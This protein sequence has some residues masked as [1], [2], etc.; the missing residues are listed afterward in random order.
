MEH[1]KL[2]R[3]DWDFSNLPDSELR[4]ALK[5]EAI[6]ESGDLPEIVGRPKARKLANAP[7][8]VRRRRGVA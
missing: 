8:D 5:W 4:P 7:S 6:R 3:E 2:I 1:G